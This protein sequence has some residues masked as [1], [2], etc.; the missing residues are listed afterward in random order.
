MK[1]RRLFFKKIRTCVT[2]EALGFTSIII[3]CKDESL[4]IVLKP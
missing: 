2:L 4:V 1:S 3:S